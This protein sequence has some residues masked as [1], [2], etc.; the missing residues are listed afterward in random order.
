[1]VLVELGKKINSALSKLNKQSTVDE[2][3]LKEVL[4]EI[5]I[6]LLQADVNAKYVSQLRQNITAQFKINQE[7]GQ[8]VRKMVQQSVVQELSGMLDAGKQPFQP[9][10]GKCNVVMFVGLQGSGKTT[11]CTKY[12]NYWKSKGWRVALVCADTFRAGAFDQL[13]QNATK[14]RVPFYGSYSETDPVAISEEGVS[15]FKKDNF[16][17]II[18]DT[19]GRH[20]QEAE[21]FEE[22]QQVDAAVSPDEIIFVMDSSIGQA[23]Y[24]QAKAF[25]S[26]VKVGSVI[27]TKLDGHAKGGGALSA[28]AA[29]ESPITFIGTGEQFEDLE[30]FEPES[31]IKRLLGMGDMKKLIEKVTDVVNMDEQGNLVNNIMKGKFSFQDLYSQ[32]Q[33]ILKLG[34]LSNFMSLMP[35]MGSGVLSPEN[36]KD[37]I[38]KV[39]RFMNIMD[40][41][42]MEERESKVK[43]NNSRIYRIAMGSGTSMQE[44]EQLIVE[45]KRLAGLVGKFTNLGGKDGNIKNQLQRNPNQLAGKLG[46][47]INP[48]MLQQMGG[49]GNV[50]NMVKEMGNMEGIGDMMKGMM[51]GGGMPDMGALQ[52][53]MSKMGGLGGLQSMLGGGGGQMPKGIPKKRR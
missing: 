44:V 38:K 23:C 2:D 1:M 46:N 24:D 21:L 19:S 36:E 31:F 53:M 35:G 50:M 29:T 13:K 42:T 10:R 7:S 27:I 48:Q 22:M 40:S 8:N 52:G 37:S 25:R 49:M 33:S 14:I 47:A 34:S 39:K 17:I 9:K 15:Q 20:K 26:C 16:E 32:F 45:H 4:Q 12:A 18:V 51:G 11:S 41:M 30:K 6:A 3:L 5:A 43:L 28:V